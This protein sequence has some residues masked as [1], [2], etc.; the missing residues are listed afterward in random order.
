MK[1][2]TP[3]NICPFTTMPICDENCALWDKT[4]KCCSFRSIAY[5]L[6]HMRENAEKVARISGRIR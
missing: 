3:L 5:S 2:E 6:R 4:D 1:R